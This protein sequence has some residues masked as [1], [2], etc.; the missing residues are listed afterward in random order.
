MKGKRNLNRTT[1]LIVLIISLS[2]IPSSCFLFGVRVPRASTPLNDDV[3]IFSVE[4]IVEE[5]RVS[6]SV[7]IVYSI[8]IN[9]GTLKRL[10]PPSGQQVVAYLPTISPDRRTI[11]YGTFKYVLGTFSD[12]PDSFQWEPTD[13]QI[14]LMSAD[15]K[16]KTKLCNS[17]GADKIEWSPDGKRVYVFKGVLYYVDIASGRKKQVE[18]FGWASPPVFAISPSGKRLAYDVGNPYVCNL[19]DDKVSGHKLLFER[20]AGP[21]QLPS[22]M[23]WISDKE[24]LFIEQE[25]GKYTAE[26]MRKGET[27]E[28]EAP[29]RSTLWR[30]NADT[31]EKK[32]LYQTEPWEIISEVTASP[33][34]DRV[35]FLYWTQG[36][37]PKDYCKDYEPGH[38]PKPA[39]LDLK[40]GKIEKVPIPPEAKD[41]TFHDLNWS[42]P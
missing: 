31:G 16:K 5:D 30:I 11:A 27:V 7:D 35:D 9:D 42:S 13:Y 41:W 32:V 38:E 23:V 3:L 15:G 17:E 2:L 40:T 18:G 14:W 10:Y 19:Q 26:S 22:S 24:L 4:S 20:K 12:E 29:Y 1:V 36:H 33:S 8:N 28:A 39:V 21:I 37:D 34:R 25:E 6:K